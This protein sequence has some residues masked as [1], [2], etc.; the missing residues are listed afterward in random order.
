ML[1]SKGHRER[2]KVWGVVQVCFVIYCVRLIVRHSDRIVLASVSIVGIVCRK[3]VPA[4]D[5]D[6]GII[7]HL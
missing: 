6:M 7:P 5:V 2:N 4:A 1:L 3:D